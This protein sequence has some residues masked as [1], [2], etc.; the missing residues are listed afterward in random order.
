M[1]D[2]KYKIKD[3]NKVNFDDDIETINRDTNKAASDGIFSGLRE[4]QK[5]IVF[6]VQ[7]I[8]PG[9]GSGING[10]TKSGKPIYRPSRPGSPPGVR[11]GRL[12]TSIFSRVEII[13]ENEIEVD[14]LWSAKH[15]FYQNYG[16]KSMLPRPF[17]NQQIFNDILEKIGPKTIVI[18]INDGM[19]KRGIENPEGLVTEKEIRDLLRDARMER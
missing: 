13:S 4:T 7:S 18:K 1:I 15:G 19:K 8:M 2:F 9:P 12:K 6:L 17:A 5:E 10:F 14:I 3:L 11:T 16:T